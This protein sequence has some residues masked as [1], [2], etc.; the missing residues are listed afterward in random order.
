MAGWGRGGGVVGAG[1][2]WCWVSLAPTQTPSGICEWGGKTQKEH[3]GL[4]AREA[5]WLR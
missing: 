4:S 5:E 1:G 2:G 3:E